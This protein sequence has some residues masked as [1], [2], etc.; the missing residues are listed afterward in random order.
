MLANE[1]EGGGHQ[2]APGNALLR[3]AGGKLQAQYGGQHEHS[4]RGQQVY[5]AP[6]EPGPEGA[7][8]GPRQQHAQQNSGD[9]RADHPA[10]LRRRGQMRGKGHDDM[11]A[12][13]EGTEEEG[14]DREARAPWVRAPRVTRR[15]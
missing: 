6:A 10:P 1:R 4:R 5:G 11:D 3:P 2:F 15:P 9:Y 14:R 8:E 7:A 13:G 12:G